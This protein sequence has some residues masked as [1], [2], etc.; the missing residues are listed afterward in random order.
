MDSVTITAGGTNYAA[1]TTTVTFAGG[2]ATRQATGTVVLTAGVVTGVTV[3][4]A[5]EGY[6]SAPTVTITDT[7]AGTGATATAVL[8]GITSALSGATFTYGAG[9][10]TLTLAGADDIGLHG[11]ALPRHRHGYIGAAW[12]ATGIAPEWTT[13]PGMMPRR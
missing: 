11:D 13:R 1:A 8:G 7:G 12:H 10:F 6:T 3:T 9:A 5:G 2:G 4:D